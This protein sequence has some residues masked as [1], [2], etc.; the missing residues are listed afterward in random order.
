ML[1]CTS[2]SACCTVDGCRQ[3]RISA[4]QA[5]F[6]TLATDDSDHSSDTNADILESACSES[7][8]DSAAFETPFTSPQSLLEEDASE[9]ET[10]PV[11]AK[12]EAPPAVPAAASASCA[13]G[14]AEEEE[15]AS[16][17]QTSQ[18][19][20]PRKQ[21]KMSQQP[22][23]S[24]EALNGIKAMR[25]SRRGDGRAP[26]AGSQDNTAERRQQRSTNGRGR[27]RAQHRGRGRGRAT[28]G[29]RG[30]DQ[31]QQNPAD[32]DSM[33]SEQ[34]AS[35]QQPTAHDG[36]LPPSSWGAE[37][38]FPLTQS[39]VTPCPLHGSEPASSAPKVLTVPRQ[40]Q[41]TTSS[42]AGVSQAQ[43]RGG[44]TN[45]G[46]GNTRSSNRGSNRGRQHGQALHVHSGP[47]Y[48]T[49]EE[50]ASQNISF[51][52]FG[53]DDFGSTADVSTSHVTTAHGA[54]NNNSGQVYQDGTEQVLQQHPHK[55]AHYGRGRGRSHGRRPTSGSNR[56]QQGPVAVPVAE[57]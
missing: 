10:V 8:V 27:G 1:C 4:V 19:E 3:R 34:A 12:R 41:N 56:R 25:T 33:G 57:N 5:E 37:T 50:P 30:A 39:P 23:S 53:A 28:S 36:E 7:A 17:S 42:P 18:W 46:R 35:G 32:Y 51:G 54:G 11:K 45:R 48:H 52:S 44:G 14:W 40:H 9:W 49:S 31:P 22:V 47:M 29:R 2:S 20:I 13:D 55:A 6:G 24:P 15:A 16:G 26:Q 43:Q 21:T 38:V